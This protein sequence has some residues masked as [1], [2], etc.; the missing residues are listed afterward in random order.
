MDHVHGSESIDRGIVPAGGKAG[1]NQRAGT[2]KRSVRLCA[3]FVGRTLVVSGQCFSCS[4]WFAHAPDGEE[5]PDRI[6]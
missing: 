5:S 3:A 6:R 2:R 4:A 1:V